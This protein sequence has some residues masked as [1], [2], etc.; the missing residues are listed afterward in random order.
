MSGLA[1]FLP[2]LSAAEQR[3]LDRLVEKGDLPLPGVKPMELLFADGGQ[4]YI[5]RARELARSAGALADTLEALEPEGST[6]PTC[7]DHGYLR[8]DVAPGHPDFGRAIACPDCGARPLMARY[9]AQLRREMR[10]KYPVPPTMLEA[11]ERPIDLSYID[12]PEILND[13]GQPLNDQERARAKEILK[14]AYRTARAW[15]SLWPDGGIFALNGPPGAAKTHLAT[16]FVRMAWLQGLSAHFVT[17][18]ELA[19]NAYRFNAIDELRAD[20]VGF[21]LLVIDEADHVYNQKDSRP[22]DLLFYIVD[23][24]QSGGRCTV[25]T[26]NELERL[27][28]ALRSRA[29]SASSHWIDLAGVPDGRP[30]FAGDPSWKGAAR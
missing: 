28:P 3:Y 2:D 15:A 10:H 11:G 16:K 21:D 13:Q 4:N 25:L 29:R 5:E 26:G 14:E 23:A 6:C 19:V 24:R 1:P 30:F 7:R 20:Y 17:G 27:W 9:R 8:R 12:S 22:A 18:G